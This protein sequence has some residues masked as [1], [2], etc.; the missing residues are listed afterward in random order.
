MHERSA[1]DRN[2]R[3]SI[4]QNV[5][6]LI[7]I[8]NRSAQLQDHSGILQIRLHEVNAS[9]LSN[10]SVS[11][12][13]IHVSLKRVLFQE[14]SPNIKPSVYSRYLVSLAGCNCSV[15]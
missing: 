3:V 11:Q 8:L 2:F 6:D 5:I 7:Q 12:S 10:Y 15:N 13:W 1:T 4:L 14:I 9:S